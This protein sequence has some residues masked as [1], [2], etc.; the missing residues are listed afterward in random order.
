MDISTLRRNKFE[1]EGHELRLKS[2]EKTLI[3]SKIRRH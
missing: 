1:E 3:S 2:K